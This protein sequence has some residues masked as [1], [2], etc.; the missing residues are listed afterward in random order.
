MIRDCGEHYGGPRTNGDNHC[1]KCQYFQKLYTE[2]AHLFQA[3]GTPWSAV[4]GEAVG[5]KNAKTKSH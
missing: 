1:Y 2:K 4:I 3:N 5:V